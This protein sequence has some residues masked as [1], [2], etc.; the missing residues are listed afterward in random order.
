[1]RT[2]PFSGD[3]ASTV[4]GRPPP[5]PPWQNPG[6]SD[7]H[8]PFAPSD[9]RSTSAVDWASLAQFLPPDKS[10]V[11]HESRKYFIT[12][13]LSYSSFV[14]QQNS[15]SGDVWIADSGVSCHNMYDVRPPPRGREFIMIGDGHRLRAKYVG[16]IDV[17][18]HEYTDER[19]TLVHLSFV[20]GLCFN[21]YSLHA[22]Q[23][24]QVFISDLSGTRIIGILRATRLLARSVGGRPRQNIMLTK[25]FLRQ[26]RHPIL[27]LARVLSPPSF[28]VSSFSGVSSTESRS[29]WGINYMGNRLKAQGNPLAEPPGSVYMPVPVYVPAITTPVHT[30]PAP[31]PAL[32]VVDTSY[33][34]TTRG[35][36][37]LCTDR[38]TAC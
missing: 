14:A 1:M 36:I 17:I 19:H 21:L 12:V 28:N 35:T 23:R 20:P 18:F 32:L 25:D 4:G 13:Q 7:D 10:C 29:Y 34:Y 9:A 33:L 11:F 38:G 16:S 27:P 30:A 26:L 22:F 31:A 37:C 15:F 6:S 8:G 2:T 24:T 5:P 3:H